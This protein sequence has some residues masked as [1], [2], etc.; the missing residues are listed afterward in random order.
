MS[1]RYK[2]NNILYIPLKL[3][4]FT[5]EMLL[6]TVQS[7]ELMPIFGCLNVFNTFSILPWKPNNGKHTVSAISLTWLD[8]LVY[9][10]PTYDIL[11]I[12]IRVLY[13]D[14]LHGSILRDGQQL[15]EQLYNTREVVCKTV[16][17]TACGIG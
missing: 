4:T 5:Y 13:N 17:V 2:K 11:T 9:Y 10:I 15:N 7:Y 12:I 8:Y 3:I 16:N 6:W 14:D 1:D